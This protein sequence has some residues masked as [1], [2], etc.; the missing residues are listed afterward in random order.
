[1]SGEPHEDEGF[2]KVIFVAAQEEDDTTYT[3]FHPDGPMQVTGTV[4]LNHYMER[5]AHL[6]ATYDRGVRDG[7]RAGME[8]AAAVTVKW[9]LMVCVFGFPFAMLMGVVLARLTS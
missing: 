7:V 2:E 5:E 9:V 1:M 4:L 8:A 3:I 6:E